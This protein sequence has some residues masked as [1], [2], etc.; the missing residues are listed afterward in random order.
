MR[1]DLPVT[2]RRSH[3]RARVQPEAASRSVARAIAILDDLHRTGPSVSVAELCRALRIPRSSAY[4]IIQPLVAGGLVERTATAG[5]IALGRRLYEFGLAYGE[6]SLL[7]QEARPVLNVLRDE[8]GETAQLAVLDHDEVLIVLKAE[9]HEPIHVATRLGLRMKVNWS[10]A[11]RLL[12]SDLSA[13]ELRL[14]LPDLV[15]PSPSGKATTDV[16]KLVRE[17]AAARKNGVAIQLNQSIQNIG[18]VAA[19]IIDEAGRCIA[20]LGI[21]VPVHRLRGARRPALARTLIGAA[22]QISERL[23]HPA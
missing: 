15:A 20:A 22:R 5:G 6:R 12:L 17:I 8:T 16:A 3:D 2:K 21:V 14:R 19:P 11:G 7:L 23:A 13:P 18:A 4:Q 9:G 1:V 10:A